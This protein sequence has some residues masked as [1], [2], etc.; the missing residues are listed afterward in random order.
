MGILTTT[1]IIDF[2]SRVFLKK[3]Y[4]EIIELLRTSGGKEY[5]KYAVRLVFDDNK[6]ITTSSFKFR[7]P[8]YDIEDFID[9]V[10]DKSQK[11]P[12]YKRYMKDFEQEAD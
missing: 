12:I 2:F 10:S 8:R 4:W 5:E 7:F 6:K 11:E 1:I 3:Y 9:F